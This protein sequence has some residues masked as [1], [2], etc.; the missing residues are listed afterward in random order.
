MDSGSPH[1]SLTLLERLRAPNASAAWERFAQLYTPLL[2]QWAQRYGLQD[3][4]VD[5]VVQDVLLKLAK[6]LPDPAR[7]PVASFRGWLR[8]ITLNAC[9]DFFRR[10]GTRPLPGADGLSGV[11]ADAALSAVVEAND[12]QTVVRRAL[13]MIRS[14]FSE[15]TWAAF[16]GLAIQERDAASVA[17]ELGI[18]RNAVHLARNRVLTRLREEFGAFLE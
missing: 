9:R 14:E 8:E 3:T 7:P 12:R 18:T 17:A 11:G 13:E 6:L 16:T 15:K 2:R 4:D 1:T 10:K 5:D